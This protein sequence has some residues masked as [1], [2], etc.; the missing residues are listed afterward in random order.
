M[1]NLLK[2]KTGDWEIVIGIEIH[3]QIISQSKLFSGSSTLV[4]LR[5]IS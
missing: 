2:G 4:Y 5:F 1:S 3:A